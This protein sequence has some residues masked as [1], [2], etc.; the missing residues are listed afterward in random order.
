[1][2]ELFE[3]QR[4]ETDLCQEHKLGSVV[5]KALGIRRVECQAKPGTE[6]LRAVLAAW[7]EATARLEQTHEAL[8]AE[9]QRLTRE[10]EQKNRELARKNRLADLGLMASH[11]AH[12]VRNNLVPVGLYLNL[13]R[14]RLAQDSEGTSILEKLEAAFRALE[15]MV[16]DLLHF[17]GD[18][19]PRPRA[20]SLR[21]LVEEAITTLE[22]QLKA[23]GIVFTN[24][25]PQELTIVADEEMLRR[26]VVNIALNSLD[27]MPDGGVLRASASVDERFVELVLADTGPGFPEEVRAKVFEPFFTTK[28]GG[29]GLGLTIVMRIAEAH[30]GSVTA[31]NAQHGGACVR[32]KIPRGVA[33]FRDTKRVQTPRG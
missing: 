30:G 24:T 16:H 25:I 7:N 9:V 33:A 1:M 8:R 15:T 13:L 19:E 18:R 3:S 17:T 2:D 11:V 22:G 31:E 5:D 12:E 6:E 21:Q 32:L 10:L 26:A 29:T 14:R 27:A 4:T 23:Q 20:T 28:P